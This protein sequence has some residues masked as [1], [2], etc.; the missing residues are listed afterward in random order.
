MDDLTRQYVDVLHALSQAERAER[1]TYDRWQAKLRAHA[2]GEVTAETLRESE[3]AYGAAREAL[4]EARWAFLRHDPTGQ[5]DFNGELEL[6]FT[7]NRNWLALQSAIRVAYDMA[8]PA[9]DTPF[10]GEMHF[11]PAWVLDACYDLAS[12]QLKRA[13]GK[14]RHSRFVTRH[15]E[16]LKDQER[17]VVVTWCRDQGLSKEE[18]LGPACEYLEEESEKTLEKAFDRIELGRARAAERFPAEWAGKLAPVFH[19]DASDEPPGN[20]YDDPLTGTFNDVKWWHRDLRSFTAWMKTVAS[21]PANSR[22]GHSL[23]RARQ[24]LAAV[25]DAKSHSRPHK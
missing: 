2:V 6:A 18:S 12:A 10:P 24:L 3:E 5:R 16:A 19:R 13:D 23:E 11:V 25:A 4:R 8:V 20:G 9:E 17:W 7:V 14:G 21:L 22:G 1:D 15:R